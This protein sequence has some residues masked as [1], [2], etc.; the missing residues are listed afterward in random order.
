MKRVLESP[1][2]AKTKGPY[3][4][5]VALSDGA[6]IYTS[7]LVARNAKGRILGTGDIRKQTRQCLKNI[8]NVIRAG[9]GTLKDLS[10]LTVYLRDL[11]DYAGM[12]EVRREML[13]GIPFASST[14]QVQLNAADALVEID[15]VA[16]VSAAARTR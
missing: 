13:A 6:L 2:V 12:N 14:V 3:V 4:Q 1:R 10:K 5:G 15:A 16:F 11:R 8:E 7:G 9:G